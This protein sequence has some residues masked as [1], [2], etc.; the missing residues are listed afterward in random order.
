V[1]PYPATTTTTRS[2]TRAITPSTTRAST[3]ATTPSTTTTSTRATTPSTTTTST[4]AAAT[5]QVVKVGF[6]GQLVFTP[7][8]V[9]VTVG[10]TVQWIDNDA[11]KPHTVTQGVDSSCVAQS[12]GFDSGR[13]QNPSTY[14]HTFN[15]TG[16]YYYFCT[17]HCSAGMS[18]RVNVGDR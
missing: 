8:I 18:G 9:N 3:R 4:R 13:L 7:S 1:Y 2:S 10:D 12:N 5:I 11:T 17:F 15:K 14:N 16:I 6:N